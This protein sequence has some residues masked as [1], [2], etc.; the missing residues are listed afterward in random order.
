MPSPT[1]AA[2]VKFGAATTVVDV[3]SATASLSRNQIDITAV[4]DAHRHTAQGFLTGTVQLEVFYDS[5]TSNAGILS[6]LSTGTKIS[7][8]EVIWAS[9]KSI[10]GDAYVQ[11]ASITVAPN[12][13]AR[14]T[15]TLLFSDNA[16]TVVA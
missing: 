15:A 4:G 8:V 12:D 14:C 3:A 5:G 1:T 16:I 10:K 11:D 6:N 2:S 13:I 7:D 9:G